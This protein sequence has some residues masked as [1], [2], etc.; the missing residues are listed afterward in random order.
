MKGLFFQ[1]LDMSVSATWLALAVILLRLVLKKA[2]KYLHCILWAMVALRLI[3]PSLPESQAS[4]IPDSQPVS[5]VVFGQSQSTSVITPVQPPADLP[6]TTVP[7]ASESNV[8]PWEEILGI[9]WVAGMAVM[10][11]YGLG[12]YLLLR[13]KVAPSVE[14]GGAWLCDNVASPFILGI[15]RPRI[16]LPSN[17]ADDCRE[18][19]LAH[20]RAHLC[21]KDHWWKPLGF[22]LLAIH[23]FNPV[24][25]LAYILLCRDIEAACDERVIKGMDLQARKQYSEALLSCAATRQY[26]AACPLAF[27]EQGVKGRIRSVLTYKKPTIWIILAALVASIVLVVCFLTNPLHDLKLKAPSGNRKVTTEYVW[28]L[29]ELVPEYF[30]ME[31]QEGFVLFVWEED[32]EIWCGLTRKSDQPILQEQLNQLPA[33]SLEGMQYILRQHRCDHNAYNYVDLQI[34]G[35]FQSLKEQAGDDVPDEAV[36]LW[37]ESQLGMENCVYFGNNLVIYGH[38]HYP[39]GE[40]VEKDQLGLCIAESISIT[41]CIFGSDEIRPKYTVYTIKGRDITYFAVAEITSPMVYKVY[42]RNNT[43]PQSDL[44]YEVNMKIAYSE[45]SCPAFETNCFYAISYD[46]KLYKVYWSDMEGLSEGQPVKVTYSNGGK[47]ESEDFDEYPDGGYKPKYEITALK[48]E[49]NSTVLDDDALQMIADTA[50]KKKFGLTDLGH[51]LISF[52]RHPIDR[53]ASVDYRLKLFGLYTG[54][55]YKVFLNEDGTVID[56]RGDYGEYARY[57]PYAT[58][59]AYDAAKAKLDEKSKRGGEAGYY[60]EIDSEGYLCLSTEI[61]LHLDPPVDENGNAMSGCGVDHD[62]QF[63]SER[64]CYYK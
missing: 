40:T 26:V 53:M 48:V 61:I 58:K 8:I 12:S 39:T 45:P 11:A 10:A 38:N 36:K 16:Y 42:Q 3:C 21:R 55:V 14:Q 24:M 27:G 13:R 44:T 25:W 1:I 5:S 52:S 35:D 17:L 28:D 23:W 46:G 63:F 4:L 57:L 50:I 20:E 6:Q 32:Q 2:P 62:H 33:V 7:Q 30:T 29:A 22:V 31:Y 51:Y 60:L 37:I 64:I 34:L 9:V 18:S 49:V 41:T 59:E 19:V 56:I 43:V 47:K 15:L 54:E